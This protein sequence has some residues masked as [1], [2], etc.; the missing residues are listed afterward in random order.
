MSELCQRKSDFT[1]IDAFHA[2]MDG[3]KIRVYPGTGLE[4]DASALEGEVKWAGDNLGLGENDLV[5]LVDCNGNW[6]TVPADILLAHEVWSRIDAYGQM[7][8]KGGLQHGS[9]S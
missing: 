9:G 8:I 6:A 4:V 3:R 5:T 7:R 2:L 1:V